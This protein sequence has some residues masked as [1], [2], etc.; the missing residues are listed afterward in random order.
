MIARKYVPV[1]REVALSIILI[2]SLHLKLIEK[3][4]GREKERLKE[5]ARKVNASFGDF[6]RVTRVN[7]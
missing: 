6:I 3:A 4:E 1:V 5:A 2:I 7:F